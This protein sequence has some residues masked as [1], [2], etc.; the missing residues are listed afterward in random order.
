MDPN[1]LSADGTIALME[2][3]FSEDGS[4]LAYSFSESGA[5]WRKIKVRNVE[6]GS[7]YNDLLKGIKFTTVSWTNDNKGF[8]YCV[9]FRD[10]TRISFISDFFS[11]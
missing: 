8:F 7:D 1:T 5:D 11:F 10:F 9:S 4:L 6:S 2:N 3:V